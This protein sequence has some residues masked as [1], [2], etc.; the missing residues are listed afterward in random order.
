MEKLADSNGRTIAQNW[1]NL[2]W[3]LRIE[4]PIY[5]LSSIGICL[6]S[7]RRSHAINWKQKHSH[8]R[9]VKKYWGG[10]GPEQ[11]GGGPSVFEP[12]VRGGSCNFSATHRGGS[13]CF[14][15]GNWHTFDTI[16]NKGNSF[17]TNKS[18]WHTQ[19]PTHDLAC[20]QPYHS[21][22]GSHRQQ[23]TPLLKPQ[24]HTTHVG[25]V[26]YA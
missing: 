18:K 19:T 12:L 15:Y 25:A 13:S 4:P 23:S 1:L 26:G 2:H 8:K 6:Q 21:G 20:A 9:L 5:A 7:K 16:Y 11:R 3:Q 10:G 24:L 14:F 22:S 17:C